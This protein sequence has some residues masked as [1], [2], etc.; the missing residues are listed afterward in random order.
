MVSEAKNVILGLLFNTCDKVVMCW[1]HSARELK[2]LPDEDPELYPH[3]SSKKEHFR[4]QELTITDIV[5][6]IRLVNTTAP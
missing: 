6:Y 1:I 2:I 4:I 3:D 5:E